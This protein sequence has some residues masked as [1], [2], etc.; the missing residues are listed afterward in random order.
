MKT[1]T[2]VSGSVVFLKGENVVL[3]PLDV[4]D[5]PHLQRW[6]NDPEVRQFL[7]SIYPIGLQ[8]EREWVESLAK[9]P[10]KDVVVMIEVSGRPIGTMGLHH[11]NWKDRTATT[12]ALIGEK[13]CWGK[14]YGTDAKM[15]LLDYAFNTLNL[16]K[17]HSRVYSFNKRSL[18]YSLHCGYKV[19]GR[20][21]REHFCHGR[22]WDVTLLELFKE[23][24]LP[25]WKKY[26]G[27]K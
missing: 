14:G 20:L 27:K 11:I 2:L 6:I 19:V 23:N 22:Y 24:W 4:T 25:Y 12:G 16:R 10:S 26:H 3:R 1:Q 7:T 8:S 13:D 18:A 5:A 21:K 17:I 15:I 9:N